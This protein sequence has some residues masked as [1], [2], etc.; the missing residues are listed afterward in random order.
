ML[1]LSAVTVKVEVPV[2]PLSGSRLED[3]LAKFR[4]D[5]LQTPPR[6]SAL[7]VAGRRAYAVARAGGEVDLVARPV[8]IDD[9]RLLNWNETELRL[10]VSCS[11]GTYI[12]ALVRDIAVSLGTVGHLA[13]LVRTR[14]GPFS[15]SESLTLEDIAGRGVANTLLPASRAMPEAPKY[16][17]DRRAVELL[18]NGRAIHV[19]GLRADCVWVY[20][21]DGR[22]IC[23]GSADGVLLRP[24]LNLC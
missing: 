5:I 6:Y 18:L 23:L 16:S 8:T 19:P 17:A 4:G 11:K 9:I 21:P 22:L 7:K 20:D 15:L 2:P 24:R 3:A 13:G 12:R 1:L 10:E 14:V